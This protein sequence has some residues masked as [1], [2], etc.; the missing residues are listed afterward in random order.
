MPL[1]V[2]HF[3]QC[4]VPTTTVAALAKC[5]TT[6]RPLAQR[7]FNAART[8]IGAAT[9]DDS[10]RQTAWKHWSTYTT[11]C[12]IDPWLRGQSKQTKQVYLLAFAARFR[13]GIFGKANQVGAQSVDKALRHVAQTLVLAGYEDPRKSYG[14]KDLDLPF[15][16]LLKSYTNEDPPPRPQ[17]ALPV[18]TITNAGAY[19]SPE[20]D[21]LT[22]ATADLVTTAFFFCYVLGN[23]L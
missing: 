11:Q 23:T 14:S 7:D 5:P 20:Y 4:L 1:P 13:T 21:A 2:P 6:F 16:L 10:N 8:A 9:V 12:N 15:R 19:Y 17:L 22:R 18:A 3:F